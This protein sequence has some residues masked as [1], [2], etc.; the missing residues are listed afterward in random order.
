MPVTLYN[1]GTATFTNASTTVAGQGTLWSG[2]VGGDVIKA[3][4]GRFYEITPTDDLHFELN[5]AYNGVTAAAAV[6]GV[7]WFL[8]RT[9]LA[10]DSVRTASKLLTD[11]S[12]TYRSVINVTAADQT[13]RLSRA[14]INDRAG[15][16]LQVAGVDVFRVGSFGDKYFSIQYLNASV[17]T[18]AL[19]VDP[20][21]ALSFGKL[22]FSDTTEATGAGTTASA[23]FQGGVEILKKLFVTGAVALTST[24]AVAGD[25]AINTNKFTVAAASGDTVVAGTL[26][27]MGNLTA[28]SI[29][30]AQ[31]GLSVQGAT[32]PSS[33]VGI[34]MVYSAGKGRIQVYDRTGAAFK[35]LSIDGSDLVVASGTASTSTT[36]GALTVGGGLGVAGA[37]NVGGVLTLGSGGNIL[38]FSSPGAGFW[39]DSYNTAS[40]FF[41]GTDLNSDGFRIYAAGYGTNA[42]TINGANGIV[43]ISAGLSVDA[44]LS[45][46]GAVTLSS[47]L[48]LGNAQSLSFKDT[49]GTPRSTLLLFSDNHLYLDNGAGGD[50]ILRTGATATERL[51]INFSAGIVSISSTVASTSTTTGA[52]TVAGGVGIGGAVNISGNLNVGGATVTLANVVGTN[53]VAIIGGGGTGNNFSTFDIDGGSGNFG[54][55]M[56]RFKKNSVT[57]WQWGHVSALSSGT[58]SDFGVVSNTYTGGAAFVLRILAA[59]G[60]LK[61]LSPTASTSTTTGA[62]IVSGGAGIAGALNVGGSILS[63]SASG[64]IGYGAGAGGSV[65]QLTNKATGVTVNKPSGKITMSNAALA[66]NDRVGFVLTNSVIGANDTVSVNISGG[67]ALDIYA[68]GVSNV[69]AGSCRISV[70]NTSAGSQSEALVITFNVIKG[71][72]T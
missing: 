70:I 18:S 25:F 26:S 34:E 39:L 43:S 12:A 10:R 56:F 48:T 1:T 41:F 4:D 2:L 32:F 57:E 64:G 47:Q 8:F 17:W 49:G 62:L 3:P 53:G 9:S 46:T 20:N 37:L 55:G 68:L 33:G 27:V 63:F 30:Q 59:D 40:R 44:T 65:T 23:I 22:N 60:A 29:I 21:G 58:S 14:S 31:N 67:T 51:R 52:L 71:T 11:V 72:I 36:T 5:V 42:L 45:V 6:G 16:Q 28:Q 24:L 19:T 7:D 38:K 50:L 66:A 13:L 69:V 54:G 15:M 61:V 35:P